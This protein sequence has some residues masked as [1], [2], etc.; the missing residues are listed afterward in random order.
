LGFVLGHPDLRKFSPNFDEI[1]QAYS[2]IGAIP[3]NAKSVDKYA[4]VLRTLIGDEALVSGLESTDEQ[5][6][7]II[8]NPM[9]AQQLV[10]VLPDTM[11]GNGPIQTIYRGI[12]EG[13]NPETGQKFKRFKEMSAYANKQLHDM[14]VRSNIDFSDTEQS[15]YVASIQKAFKLKYLIP[16]AD[17]AE[18]PGR[19]KK[20]G[21]SIFSKD[22]LLGSAESLIRES[23]PSLESIKKSLGSLLEQEL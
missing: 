21:G 16:L 9:N 11:F 22:T 6:N 13:V 3:K 5:G 12:S 18:I 14:A 2:N 15:R 8:E 20:T 17:M 10:D 4:G 19:P 7:T 23:S 1:S